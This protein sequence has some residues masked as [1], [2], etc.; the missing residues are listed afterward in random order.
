[1][2][3]LL[4]LFVAA[5]PLT[6]SALEITSCIDSLGY[7]DSDQTIARAVAKGRL[8][9][10]LGTTVSATTNLETKTTES[11]GEVTTEDT[12]TNSITL[13][14]ENYVSGVNV[15][16]EGYEFNNGKKQYCVH[17]THP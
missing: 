5:L 3:K 14:S 2:N 10:E 15:V 9:L 16:R 1:M 11:A 17:L 8:S 12:L 4:P 13:S 7:Y 6:S